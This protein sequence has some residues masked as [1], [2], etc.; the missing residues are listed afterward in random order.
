MSA[1]IRNKSKTIRAGA[2]HP[3]IGWKPMD[4]RRCLPQFFRRQ[5]LEGPVSELYLGHTPG[6]ITS[7][8]Y[9]QPN[10]RSIV[11]HSEGERLA[12]DEQ[13]DLFRTRLIE[14]LNRAIESGGKAKILNFFEKEG[15]ELGLLDRQT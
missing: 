1:G 2:G 9:A 5:N 8:H 6:D 15:N 12:L 14:P 10:S 13:M 3:N 11:R 4:F 7:S